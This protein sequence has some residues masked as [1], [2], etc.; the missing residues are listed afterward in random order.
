MINKHHCSMLS[1]GHVVVAEPLWEGC[2]LS[3]HGLVVPTGEQSVIDEGV[4]ACCKAITKEGVEIVLTHGEHEALHHTEVTAPLLHS[5]STLSGRLHC[6]LHAS[7]PHTYMKKSVLLTGT[8]AVSS[9]LCEAASENLIAWSA[10]Q[11]RSLLTEIAA[12]ATLKV[13]DFA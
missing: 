13:L 12:S 6:S 7:A 3:L 2:L 1:C 11:S 5:L 4:V 9:Q 10:F 8:Q